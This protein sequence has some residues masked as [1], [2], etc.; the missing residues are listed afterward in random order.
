MG[1]AP[2]GWVGGVVPESVVVARNAKAVILTEA[3]VVYPTGIGM[4]LRAMM[5]PRP[6]ARH[7]AAEDGI[8]RRRR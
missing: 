7:G 1:G 3:I 2:P 6:S 5:R 4:R 8:R